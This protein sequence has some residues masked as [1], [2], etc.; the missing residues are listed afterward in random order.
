M[1]E[2]RKL[3]KD[4]YDELFEVLTK[5][6]ENKYKRP[7]Y[8][9]K[10]QPKMWIRDD[11]H[12]ARHTGVFEDGKL[13]SVVG[14][15]PLPLVIDGER[16]M[17][18]TTG[19]VATLPAYEGKG[20]FTTLFKMAMQEIVDLGADGARLGGARQRYGR[21]GFEGGGSLFKFAVAVENVRATAPD[22]AGI[23]FKKVEREDVDSI[24]YC[25]EMMQKK[26]IFVD[27]S[28]A[29]NYRDMYLGLITKSNA[30]YLV[31]RDGEPIGYFCLDANMREVSEFAINSA[32]DLYEAVCAL[33][34]SSGNREVYIH[35]PPHLTEEL[36]YFS[37][38]ADRADLFTP[39]RFKFLNY[40]GIASALLR[41]KAK[42]TRL[43]YFDYKIN[44]KDYGTIR[45]YN[46]EGGAGC[47]RVEC[48]GD[49]SL[50]SSEAIRLLYS[51]TPTELIAD[52]PAEF[53][54]A[55][56][57]PLSWVTLDYV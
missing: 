34:A 6:F 16:F 37:D 1:V 46:T 57:L 51:Y 23:T 54:S 41:L 15:Y 18:Y 8:F 30:P 32:K 47:E 36:K 10:E 21:F 22:I 49:I 20:Y 2:I 3:N 42:K 27:R 14:V 55:L 35:I 26:E 11:E 5:T 53:K 28:S 39:S 38:R 24:R 12:M 25:Y 43:S 33:Q 56:P 50:T 31:L 17:L 29:E 40:E 45:L 48:E 9:D 4:D 19:N 44:I 52:L 7:V 13:V